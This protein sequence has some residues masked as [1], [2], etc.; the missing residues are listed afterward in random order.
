MLSFRVSRVW[1]QK[2]AIRGKKLSDMSN[3]AG[4]GRVCV[5]SGYEAPPDNDENGHPIRKMLMSSMQW[6]NMMYRSIFCLKTIFWSLPFDNIFP[7]GMPY[8]LC[9]TYAGIPDSSQCKVEIT[10]KETLLSPVF[11]GK[12]SLNIY[13][14]FALF[15]R[16]QL[17][18]KDR[19]SDNQSME[20]G[21]V[22]FQ[23]APA[24]RILFHFAVLF[25]VHHWCPA[26]DEEALCDCHHQTWLVMHWHFYGGQQSRR[27]F[28]SFISPNF[29]TY[30]LI[31]PKRCVK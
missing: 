27:V 2:L 4:G 1:V 30:Y 14:T 17:V 9:T 6:W 8:A 23:N 24:E 12:F 5:Y 31:N 3:M 7:L 21:K 16:L 11:L 26:H 22:S 18:S 15:H 19:K 10:F 20:M 25:F 28:F 13:E 29:S